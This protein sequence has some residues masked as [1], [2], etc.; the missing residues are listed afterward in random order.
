M[1]KVRTEASRESTTC[2]EKTQFI[3]SCTSNYTTYIQNTETV[4]QALT[5]AS[6]AWMMMSNVFKNA[7]KEGERHASIYNHGSNW[8]KSYWR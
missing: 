8:G 3:I 1:G 4:T 5:P 7:W 6:N 2:P